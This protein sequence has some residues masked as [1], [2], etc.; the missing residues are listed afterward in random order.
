MAG[1]AGESGQGEAAEAAAEVPGVSHAGPVGQ[2]PAL[3]P[4]LPE[5]RMAH[6]QG[7]VLAEFCPLRPVQA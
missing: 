2:M 4:H 1:Y 5:G 7:A 3:Q 6:P